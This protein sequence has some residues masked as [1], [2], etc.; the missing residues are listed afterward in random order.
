MIKLCTIVVVFFAFEIFKA[1]ACNRIRYA[2]KCY[3]CQNCD[4]PFSEYSYNLNVK[5]CFPN[6]ICMVYGLTI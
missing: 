4:E 1:T 3:E 6:Q 2:S 5:T